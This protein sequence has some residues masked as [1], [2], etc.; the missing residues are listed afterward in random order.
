MSLRSSPAVFD[1]GA[2][3]PEQLVDNR[4]AAS[5]GW[6]LR[7][8]Q[9]REQL[10]L[11]AD[12]YRRNIEAI[13]LGCQAR[14][15]HVLLLTVPV[16]LKEWIPVAS[17]H[18][19]EWTVGEALRWQEALRRGVI[20]LESGDSERAEEALAAAVSLDPGHAETRFRLGTARHRLGDLEGARA[21]FDAA[22]RHDAFPV[23]SVF[24][25]LV[26]QVGARR[27]VPVVDA[28]ALLEGM[29]SDG[30]IGLDVLVDYVHPSIASN[31]AIAHEVLGSMVEHG[32]LPADPA[33]PLEAVRLS[34]P[35]ELE[36]ELWTLRGLFGQYLAMRQYD[37]LEKLA[38]RIH[39][40]VADWS[41][42]LEAEERQRLQDLLHKVD[43]TMYVVAPYRRLLRAQKLGTVEQEFSSEE[44]E[45]IVDAYVELVRSTE[46]R[47]LTAQEFE[48]RLARH[49]GD[50]AADGLVPGP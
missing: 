37:G 46:G 1:V 3:G 18:R 20:A 7:L 5:F 41:P 17:V 45:A 33:V 50:G 35:R 36:E 32:M 15:V 29:S 47:F 24:N 23:R 30:I 19:D 16:N 28:R 34:Y 26:Y 22:L 10:R 38:V 12:R 8:R 4:I 27:R 48:R 39:R 40:E 2:F 42:G 49:R 14:G 6:P 11:V 9:S 25:H 21:E 43:A 31:E 13:V 44:V